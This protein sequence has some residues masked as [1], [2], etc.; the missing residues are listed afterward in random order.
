MYETRVLFGKMHERFSDREQFKP[1]R[2]DSLLSD[3]ERKLK[4]AALRIWDLI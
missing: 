4:Q 2:A 3:V 1:L